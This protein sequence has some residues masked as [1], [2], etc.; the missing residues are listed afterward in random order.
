MRPMLPALLALLALLAAPAFAQAV[1]P[2]VEVEDESMM[3]DV[4]G[5]DVDMLEDTDIVDASG[6]TIGEVD[7]VL[8]DA[9]GRIVAVSAEVGGFL[10]LGDKEVVIDL[11]MLTQAGDKLAVDMTEE[12]VEALPAWDD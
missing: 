3:V 1:T 8:M 12:Q 6:E 10:G 5:V 11:G 7:E 4:F 9:E 2:L